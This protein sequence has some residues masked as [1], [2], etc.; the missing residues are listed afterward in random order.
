[1]GFE[2]RLQQD[3]GDYEHIF[4]SFGEIDCREDEGILLYCQKTG[5]A[6]QDV[7]KSTATRYFK[8]TTK[9]LSRQKEKLIYFGIPAPFW[10]G[11]SSEESSE[12][13]KRRLLAIVIFNTTLAKRCQES[14]ILFADVYKLTSRTD[15]YNNNR[16][17]L[18]STHLKPDALNVL[19][20]GFQH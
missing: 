17:M 13:N 19:V 2:K 4:L 11:P 8:L 5:N 15:G 18:D 9:L 20:K 1:M 12:H 3:L 10:L 16:W 6:I 14:G 7:A